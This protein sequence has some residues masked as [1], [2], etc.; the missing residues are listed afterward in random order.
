MFRAEHGKIGRNGAI[1]ML[2]PEFAYNP[3]AV[4]RFF[5]EARVV[6]CINHEHIVE[7]EDF[8]DGETWCKSPK[9]WPRCT[10]SERGASRFEAGQRVF[11]ESWWHAGF[12][13][14]GPL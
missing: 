11:G 1:K 6:N 7:I 12:R 10:R 4:R 9:R 13:E 8:V 3:N 14:D 5:D 2:K